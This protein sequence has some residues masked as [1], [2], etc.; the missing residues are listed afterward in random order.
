M[1]SGFRTKK[2]AP[3]ALLALKEA[4]THV[5]WYKPDLRSF[6]THC[7]ADPTI[8]SRL[9]WSDYKRNIVSQLIDVLARNEEV[10]QRQLLRLMA[11]VARI[12]DFSHLTRC[13][14]HKYTTSPLGFPWERHAPAWLLE[15][16][17]SPAFPGKVLAKD[18]RN[19]HL[20]GRNGI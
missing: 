16:G 8:L 12:S 11:E 17:W 19:G 7:L 3:A 2:I 13:P 5:Y 1:A 15:P 14:F 20:A 6:L 10:Y 9:N 18:L 4:L